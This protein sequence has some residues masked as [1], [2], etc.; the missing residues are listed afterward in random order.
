MKSIGDYSESLFIFKCIQNNFVVCK[1]FSQNSR[2]DFIID[3]KNSLYR[4]QVKCTNFI[5][6]ADNQCHVRIDYTKEEIDWFAIHMNK[7]E[8][9]YILPIEVVEGMK[10]FCVTIDK[11]S[12]YDIFKNNFAFLRHGF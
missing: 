7:M 2:Y 3:V 6:P 10:R 8:C 12:K 4:V 11:S 9:W 1:P 5:R